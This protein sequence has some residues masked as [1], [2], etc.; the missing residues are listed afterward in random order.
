[1]KPVFFVLW[2]ALIPGPFFALG[3]IPAGCTLASSLVLVALAWYQIREPHSDARRL[4]ARRIAVGMS[5]GLAGDV[6]MVAGVLLAAMA[7]FAVGHFFY[8]RAMLGLARVEQIGGAPARLA[9]WVVALAVGAGIWY[10]LVFL[11]IGKATGYPA[12]VYGG[13]FYTLFLA[14]MTGV[15]LGLSARRL[16]FAALGLGGALFLASDA[17]IGARVFSPDAFALL[18]D[19]IRNDLVWLTYAP[20]QLLIVA[21]AGRYRRGTDIA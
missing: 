16:E 12:I 3:R 6:L 14:S 11:G 9:L 17:V 20:A 15:A 8:M 19:A 2:A 4:F 21:S 1:M 7:V 13:L 18:P 5:F 10:E